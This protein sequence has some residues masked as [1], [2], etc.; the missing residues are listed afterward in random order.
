V[1]YQNKH[2]QN[3]TY[4]EYHIANK[5]RTCCYIHS[6]YF[7]FSHRHHMVPP[8]MCKM[9]ATYK[10]YN[11]WSPTQKAWSHHRQQ[12]HKLTHVISGWAVTQLAEKL[13]NNLR[14]DKL[15]HTKN[16]NSS[17]EGEDEKICWYEEGDLQHIPLLMCKVHLGQVVLG[18][19]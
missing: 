19:C 14:D 12:W 10:N 8:M 11:H 13:C 2:F 4:L 9:F 18:I 3:T 17:G 1:F 6:R 7:G 15:I 5:V 16:A